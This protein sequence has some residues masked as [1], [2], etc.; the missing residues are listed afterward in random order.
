M[1]LDIIS[2]EKSIYKGEADLVT[3]PGING[4]FTILDRHAPI[5]SVLVK[6]KV[7]YRHE[8]ENTEIEIDG[9]FVEMKKGVITVCIE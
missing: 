8:G 4:S 2:P 5:I 1:R 6:G 7:I 9:G 3:L